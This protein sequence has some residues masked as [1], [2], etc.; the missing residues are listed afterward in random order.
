MRRAD[1]PVALT[2]AGSDSCGGAGVQ[3][4]LKVFS[5]LEVYGAAVITAVTAQNSVGV[6]GFRAVPARLVAEQLAAVLADL[7]VGAVK[8]GMLWSAEN[9]RAVAREIGI[10][11]RNVP[12]VID[13]VIWA[14]DGSRLL[15]ERGTR[16]LLKHLLPLAEVITP[17]LGEVK[18][19][20]GLAVKSAE[21]ARRAAEKLVAMGAKA[22]LVKGGH[23]AG[24]AVDVFFDGRTF[25]EF[26]ARERAPGVIHGT[27]C[28][29]SAAITGYLA[30]GYALAEAIAC[31]H[32]DIQRLI[33]HA[34]Q[35]GKGSLLLLPESQA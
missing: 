4:D 31:A 23:L 27:G 1:I 35:L 18:S 21:G 22:A 26:R 16:A 19:L 10:S 15:S 34:I 5:A 13:P 8:T 30:R 11:G 32:A 7:P 6:R 12:L 2:I 9:V 24:E 14:K 29:L 25:R 3:M 33:H 20:C 28:A 17:N